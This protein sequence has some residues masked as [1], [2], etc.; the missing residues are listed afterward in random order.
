MHLN[1]LRGNANIGRERLWR[2][3]NSVFVW[4]RGG[5]LVGWLHLPS[6]VRCIARAATIRLASFPAATQNPQALQDAQKAENAGTGTTAQPKR[7]T[8]CC[9]AP[10]RR[11]ERSAQQLCTGKAGGGTVEGEELDAVR[12]V[13]AMNQ[14]VHQAGAGFLVGR[15]REYARRNAGATNA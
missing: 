4:G 9:S 1:D 7:D 2:T 8:C 5:A 6:A 13:A 11:A 15:V 3:R 12:L 10:F 14:P